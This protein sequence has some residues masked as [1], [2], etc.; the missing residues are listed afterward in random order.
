[1]ITVKLSGGLG[2]Q[3]FQYALGRC[4]AEKNKTQLRL[5]ISGLLHRLPK[6]N[7]TYRDFVLDGFKVNYTLNFFSR[8]ARF[9]GL[10]NLLFIVSYGYFCF[11]NKI[12]PAIVEKGEFEFNQEI[13]S[14]KDGVYLD[15]YWQNEK[16]FAEVAEIIRD[17][18]TLSEKLDIEEADWLKSIQE[19][20]SVALHVRRGDYV[21]L[22]LDG[23]CNL[24]YYCS[25]MN[26]MREKTSN[27]HFFIFSDD[28]KWAAEN[29]KDQDMNIVSSEEYRSPCVDMYLM[30]QCKHQIIANSSYSWWAAWLNQNREKIVI[31]PGKWTF[32]TDASP[33]LNNWLKIQ[34]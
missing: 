16:Y 25:A 6:K 13:L 29:F 30:S 31:S 12:R 9:T 11:H 26:K 14:L 32:N 20:N 18:F 17:E 33:A 3:M 23:I 22:H 27:P 34:I 24:E 1:M 5:D 21:N 7:F 19:N 10:H 2:N 8:V 15:G 4:L 28:P